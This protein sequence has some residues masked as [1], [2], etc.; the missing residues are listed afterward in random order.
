MTPHGE[1]V[2]NLCQVHEI[3]RA[4]DKQTTPSLGLKATGD[5]PP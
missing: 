3:P 5:I 2:V 4:F 1:H